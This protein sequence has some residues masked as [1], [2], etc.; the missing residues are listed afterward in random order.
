MLTL[1]FV[2]VLH[3]LRAPFTISRDFCWH[4]GS[5]TCFPSKYIVV[6]TMDA[7]NIASIKDRRNNSN[8]SL[9]W[10]VVVPMLAYSK[11]M[12]RAVVNKLGCGTNMDSKLAKN[13]WEMRV[14][15]TT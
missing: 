13:V 3:N 9:S 15:G 5:N 6:N 4:K 10:V 2:K 14:S 1:P 11:S 7:C 8:G 12:D